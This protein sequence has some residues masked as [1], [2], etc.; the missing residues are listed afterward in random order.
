M[1]DRAADLRCPVQGVP[2]RVRALKEREAGGGASRNKVLWAQVQ[3]SAGRY[4]RAQHHRHLWPD[5]ED[6]RALALGR[7]GQQQEALGLGLA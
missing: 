1:A 5:D 3:P 6:P 2:N 4:G 7:D